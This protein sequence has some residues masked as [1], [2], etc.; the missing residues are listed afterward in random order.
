MDYP[1]LPQ[2]LDHSYGALDCPV[3]YETTEPRI[4]CDLSKHAG[5][6]SLHTRQEMAE[7]FQDGPYEPILPRRAFWRWTV[8]NQLLCSIYTLQFCASDLSLCS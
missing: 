6:G 5:E 4:P 2:E 1:L 3:I 7:V 8:F